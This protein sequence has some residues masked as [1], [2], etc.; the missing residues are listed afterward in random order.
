MREGGAGR[1]KEEEQHQSGVLV[2]SRTNRSQQR[3]T[4]HQLAL[5]VKCHSQHPTLAP[6]VKLLPVDSLF[7]SVKSSWNSF[8][9]PSSSSS[10]SSSFLNHFHLSPLLLLHGILLSFVVGDILCHSLP[11]FSSCVPGPSR[12]PQIGRRAAAAVNPPPQILVGHSTL[13]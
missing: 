4:E 8:F 5:L 9:F 1:R 2:W 11:F 7:F 3:G 10:S 12:R 13:G 6:S